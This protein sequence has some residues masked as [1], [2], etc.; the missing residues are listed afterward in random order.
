MTVAEIDIAREQYLS[1]PHNPPERFE[2]YIEQ[3]N[4]LVAEIAAA[5]RIIPL[6]TKLFQGDCLAVMQSLR[7]RFDHIVCDPPYAIDMD[8][9]DQ[10]NLGITNIA[11]VSDEH[12]VEGNKGLLK[13]FIQAAW[14]SM[15]SNG[16]LIM[17]ADYSMW[18]Y[19]V[20]TGLIVGFKVQRWP[21]VW[22]KTH[23]C[24]NSAAQY[25][26]TKNTE[27]AIV[28]RK[29]AATLAISGPSGVIITGHDDFRKTMSH[30][31]VKPFACWEHLVRS[32]SIEGQ[33]ILDP[34]CG[35][36]SSILSFIRLKRPFLGIELNQDHYS[37]L[38]ENVRNEYTRIDPNC[39]FA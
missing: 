13:G 22:A 2:E 15:K 23:Q 29:G 27:I 26:F 36:G 10:T 17:W 38:L 3:K 24:L 31:F 28:M 9:L 21:I 6:S 25:N 35:E 11:S 8:N 19:I 5:R 34:F 30:P 12:E 39:A 14:D 4:A 1:N 20:G 37:R 18:D 7:G 16:Y 32:V 33:T